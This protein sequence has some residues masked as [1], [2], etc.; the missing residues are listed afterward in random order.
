[1][2]PQ[3]AILA[4]EDGEVLQGELIGKPGTTHG[5]VVFNTAMTGYQEILTDPSYAGQIIVFTF[6][7][8]GIYGVNPE[9]DQGRR[10]FARG[11]VVSEY[12]PY[13]DNFR[14]DRYLSDKLIGDGVTGI[15]GIDTRY[16]TKKIRDAG[17]MK[18]LI[19]TELTEAEAKRALANAPTLSQEDVVKEV[20]SKE[21]FDYPPPGR[22]IAPNALEEGIAFHK[23]I[24]ESLFYEEL[25]G[26]EA[27][28]KLRIAVMDFGVKFAI[29]DNLVK[30]GCHVRVFPGTSSAEEILA[31]KPDGILISNG[32][33][34]PARCEFAF[35]TIRELS[36]RLPTFGICLGHQLI[37]YAYGLSCYK[38]KF[39]HRGANHPVRDLKD[40]RAHITSQNHSY[41]VKLPEGF[42]DEAIQRSAAD[43]SHT[44]PLT[45]TSEG[46]PLP[47]EA[48]EIG[49][50]GL[51]LDKIHINDGT[52]EGMHHK[53]LP[54]FS[55]QYHPE[56]HPGPDDNLYLFDEFIELVR[57]RSARG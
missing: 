51:V 29:L 50:T 12:E 27:G 21:P 48:I 18:A 8:I 1:M 42:F 28:D 55:V 24:T 2:K 13:M 39:G 30:R 10:I 40:I 53:S 33:G 31:Y 7:L 38:M 14:A 26:E 35:Q 43:D 6:P 20:V 23:R 19:T 41:A 16:L 45:K 57:S 56:G 37:A 3:K 32:P 54:F 11:L 4:L 9:D 36:S 52:V 15:S 17:E 46:V 34:D 47:T 49:D 5:E 25:A 44:L 22:K